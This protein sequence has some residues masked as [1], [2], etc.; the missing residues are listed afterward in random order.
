MPRGVAKNPKEKGRKISE[1]RL[2]KSLSE[3]HKRK[4]GDAHRGKVTSEI[5]IVKMRLVA[6]GRKHTEA[7]KRK[8]SLMNMG[9]RLSPLAYR[10]LSVAEKKLKYSKERNKKIS[11]AMMGNTNWLGRKHSE[12]TKE[13]MRG[14]RLRN[15]EK[16]IA[17]IVPS[18]NVSACK[19]LFEPLNKKLVDFGIPEGCHAENGGEFK[20]GKYSVDYYNSFLKLV[21]EFDERGHYC[22]GKLKEADLNR[23]RYIEQELECCFIRVRDGSWDLETVFFNIL[24]MVFY[25]L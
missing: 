4:I 2:G 14:A 18:Y 11:V 22:N 20:V 16:G 15:I 25:G 5:T 12:E 8:L 13:K 10:K 21:I 1:A 19:Y 6:T 9:K 24:S 3:E 17:L 7:T 23:Q